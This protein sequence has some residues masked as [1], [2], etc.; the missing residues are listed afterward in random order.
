MTCQDK[1]KCYEKFISIISSQKEISRAQIKADRI[2]TAFLRCSSHPREVEI[3]ILR[4]YIYLTN[5]SLSRMPVSASLPL[6]ENSKKRIVSIL[7]SELN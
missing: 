7:K 1:V 5:E 3:D 4:L 6:S 2:L